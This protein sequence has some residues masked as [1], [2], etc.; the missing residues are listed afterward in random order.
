MVLLFLNLVV[1][2]DCFPPLQFL[3]GEVIRLHETLCHQKSDNKSEAKNGYDVFH[4]SA[5]FPNIDTCG[6]ND[7][8]DS[9]PE[10]KNAGN[11]DADEEAVFVAYEKP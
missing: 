4:I 3:I 5:A 6:K 8:S 9:D 1:A 7:H 2:I 11:P 10:A